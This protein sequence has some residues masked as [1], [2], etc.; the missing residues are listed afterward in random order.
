MATRNYWLDAHID[1]RTTRLTGGPQRKDGG[2]ELTVY[3]RQDGSRAK[4]LIVEGR[5]DNGE[6]TLK[7][8][9]CLPLADTHS[10]GVQIVRSTR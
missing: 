8:D 1:G 4:A 7:I 3:M 2:F 6:L 5:A 10:G 9:P